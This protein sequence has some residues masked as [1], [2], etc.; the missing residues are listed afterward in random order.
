LE[1][2]HKYVAVIGIDRYRVWNPLRNAV[3]DA[4]GALDAFVKI[5]F[6]PFRAPLIDEAATGTALHHLVT[7]ELRRLGQADSL[8]VFFAGHG[9]TL[10]SDFTNGDGPRRGY[11]IPADGDGRDGS[12]G[13]WLKL[14]SWLGDITQLPPRHILVILDACHSGI[15]LDPSTRWRGAGGHRAAPMDRL[16]ARRSRRVLTS[17]LDDEVAMDGGP[18][19]GHSLFTGCLIEALGGELFAKLKRPVAATS[20]LWA[21]VR[22]RVFAFSSEKNWK[23]TPEF[24]RLDFDDHGEL[25]IQIPEGDSQAPLG[26]KRLRTTQGGSRSPIAPKAPRTG[27]AGDRPVRLVRTAPGLPPPPPARASGG[28]GGLA[29]AVRRNASGEAPPPEDPGREPFVAMLDCHATER[30]H[31]AS[32]LSVVEGEADA[33]LAGWATWA[34]LRGQLTVVTES[35]APDA[36]I[37]DLLA[38]AP[39][40]RTLQ[41]ARRRLA[42]AARLSPEAVDAALDARAPSERAAWI[43]EVADLD[44]HARVSGWLLSALREPRARVP[45]LATAPA[46]SGYDLFAIL[47][48]LAAPIAVLLHRNRP[49]AAWL[50]AAFRTAAGLVAWIPRYAVAVGAPRELLADVL[51][52]NAATLLMARE[53]VV[54]VVGVPAARSAPR[55]SRAGRTLHTL[56]DALARDPRTAG[57]FALN[58]LVRYDDRSTVAA[59][60]IAEGARLA[61]E[62]DGWYRFRAPQGY[63]RERTRDILLQR[64]GYFVMRFLAD[65]VEDRLASTV[66]EIAI[67]LAARRAAA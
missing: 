44:R 42:S 55:P 19:A 34:A 7:H 35:A 51:Y 21:H 38:Q 67:A 65:D 60:L 29:V 37:A 52:R 4:C 16:R 17:A 47:C 46:A 40:L 20:E 9:H 59:D 8:V 32:V 2:G 10:A 50:E 41:A 23:Q 18:I 63:R 27:R 33:T 1:G 24:G 6:E 54:P 15:A 13:T 66:D 43:D 45:D 28:H 22:E 57:Q 5:G 64:A 31:G 62:I 3:R 12:I 39:W 14:E 58:A 36:A 26:G 49:D 53:G 30:T 25:V 56:H 11:L 48:D 61:V